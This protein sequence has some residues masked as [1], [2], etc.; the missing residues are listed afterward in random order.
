MVNSNPGRGKWVTIYS[1]AGH[2]SSPGFVATL[3]P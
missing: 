3:I 2:W 1:N